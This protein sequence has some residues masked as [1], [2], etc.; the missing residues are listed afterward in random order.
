M[1]ELESTE[2]TDGKLAFWVDGREEA[3]VLIYTPPQ[4]KMQRYYNSP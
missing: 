1:P 2:L 4:D 3:T